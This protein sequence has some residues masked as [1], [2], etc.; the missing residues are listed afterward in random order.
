MQAHHVGGLQQL[1]EAEGFRLDGGGRGRRCWHQWGR[2]V[3]ADAAARPMERGRGRAADD[4]KAHDA[5]RYAVEPGQIVGDHAS[6]E[7]HIVAALDLGVREGEP[8]QQQ[9]R[10]RHG[11]FGDRIVA[12]DICDRNAKPRHFSL[13]EPVQPGAGDLHELQRAAFKQRCS[14][15]RS[16]CRNDQRLRSLDALR[17]RSIVRLE[18]RHGQGSWR[19]NAEPR[20]ISFGPQAQDV[21]AHP[22]SRLEACKFLRSRR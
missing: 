21:R 9:R 11:I 20:E 1:V 19:Q 16:D 17:K 2:V 14:E 12:G 4:A 7:R 3:V 18:I 5:D 10:R 8:A 6:T 22:S 13:V 15:L